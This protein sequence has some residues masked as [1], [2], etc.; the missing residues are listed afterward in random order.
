MMQE[1]TIQDQCVKPMRWTDNRTTIPQISSK[2][3]NTVSFKK[4]S[5]VPNS[6]NV[7]HLES[8]NLFTS[9]CSHL[10]IHFVTFS[11]WL[12]RTNGNCSSSSKNDG[13][14]SSA[15]RLTPNTKH[16][17]DKSLGHCYCILYSSI[18]RGIFR[19]GAHNYWSKRKWAR[20]REGGLNQGNQMEVRWPFHQQ[21]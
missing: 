14:C 9:L 15:H 11:I 1:R 16:D 19:E 5:T 6:G 8:D 7:K 17:H 20:R 21:S 12:N 18:A 13:T 4:K 10:N 3:S 2:Q